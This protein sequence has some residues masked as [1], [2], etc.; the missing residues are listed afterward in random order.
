MSAP[1][2]TPT[3]VI[4]FKLQHSIASDANVYS[5]F[6]LHYSGTAPTTAALTTF[7][8]IAGSVYGSSLSGLLNTGAELVAA[9]AVD[10]AN[11]D[12]PEGEAAIGTAGTLP[13]VAVPDN[14]AFLLNFAV[15][16]RYRG[17]KPKMFLPFGSD[18]YV[19]TPQSW[20]SDFVADVEGGWNAFIGDLSGEVEDGCTLGAQ[21][22]VSYYGPPTVVNTGHGRNR[23]SSTLRDPPLVMSVTSVNGSPI[24]GSQRRRLRPRA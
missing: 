2:P 13:G 17:A 5:R 14:V 24:F 18:E 11:P 20:T 21:A 12:T 6:C 22:A 8:G 10:L 4:Q 16:R 19:S 9:T 23:Y 3:G 1:L 15:N 7:C